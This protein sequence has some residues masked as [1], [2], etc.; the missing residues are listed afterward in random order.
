M[1]TSAPQ[2]V[3]FYPEPFA[4]EG[5]DVVCR[6]QRDRYT[7][8]WPLRERIGILFWRI[9]WFVLCRWTPPPLNPW[10]VGVLKLFGAQISGRP[11]VAASAIIR[12]PWRLRLMDRA[13]LGPRCEVYNLGWVTL[14][15]RATVAP[16][17]LLCGGSHDFSKEHWPLTTGPITLGANCFIGTRAI[18]LLGVMIGNSAI[19]GAGAVVAKNIAPYSVVVGNPARV[20]R[21]HESEREEELSID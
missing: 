11:Y 4:Q 1:K 3:D 12:A 13:C 10:R 18:V 14:M 20:I 6:P 9:A 7:S 21:I 2:P 8:S 19:V 5:L 16:Y 17:A 15:D